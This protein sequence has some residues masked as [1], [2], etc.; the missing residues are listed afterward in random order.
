M[1]WTHSN[2]VCITVG[3]HNNIVKVDKKNCVFRLTL[4]LSTQIMEF[5]YKQ[6][7]KLIE[8]GVLF[9]K[10]KIMKPYQPF[11]Y[12]GSIM[13]KAEWW[14]HVSY[15]LMPNI[16]ECICRKVDKKLRQP[17][18]QAFIIHFRTKLTWIALPKTLTDSYNRFLSK[19][20]AYLNYL[21]QTPKSEPYFII[22]PKYT[23]LIHSRVV[24][25]I[26]SL[27]WSTPCFIT[28]LNW[29]P[30]K[31]HCWAIPNPNILLR[32]SQHYCI[33]EL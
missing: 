11:F 19:A 17:A 14:T 30:T 15:G 7:Y 12:I 5:E 10:S 6:A 26:L 29:T 16:A 9:W 24:Y 8:T 28:L 33:A 4:G 21:T 27:C 25:A 1:V 31:S 23:V 2:R 32:Y 20:Q 3:Y 18:L 13:L 22:L